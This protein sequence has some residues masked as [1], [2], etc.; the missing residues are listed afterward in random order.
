MHC[1]TCGSPSVVLDTRQGANFTTLRRRQCKVNPM[2]RFTSVECYQTVFNSAKPRALGYAASLR[3]RWRMR[4][5]DRGIALDLHKGWQCLAERFK[6]SKAA[7]YLAAQ[8][9]RRI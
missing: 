6:M 9:G 3:E 4:A 1:P 8:R 5:R 2:H 7:V